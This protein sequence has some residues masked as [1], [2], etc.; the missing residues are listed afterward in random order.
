MSA[1]PNADSKGRLSPVGAAVTLLEAAHMGGLF[2]LLPTL[3]FQNSFCGPECSSNL[4]IDYLCNATNLQAPRWLFLWLLAEAVFYVAMKAKLAYLQSIDPQEA[5]FKATN[6]MTIQERQVL[7]D[8]VMKADSHDMLGYL[9][10]WFFD[11]PMEEISTEELRDFV[12][13]GYFDNRNQEHLSKEETQQ[14]SRFV[15]QAMEQ[16]RIQKEREQRDEGNTTA[17]AAK[18]PA[19]AKITSLCSSATFATDDS[20]HSSSSFSMDDDESMEESCQWAPIPETENAS[21]QLERH[22]SMFQNALVQSKNTPERELAQMM[23]KITELHKESQNSKLGAV[24]KDRP[25]RFGRPTADPLLGVR[26]FPLVVYLLVFLTTEIPGRFLLGLLGFQRCQVGS[27]TYHYRPAR[28]NNEEVNKKKIPLVF[29]H[30]IGVGPIVYLPFVAQMMLASDRA[31]FL[32]EVQSVSAFRPWIM[33]KDALTPDQVAVSLSL[34]LA[35]QGFGQATFAAHSFGTFWMTYMIKY[36][37]DYVAGVVF[38]DPVN[39]CL[40]NSTLTRRVVYNTPDAGDVGYMI[41]TDMMV[42]W[43]VQRNFSWTRGNMF[44]EDLGDK[45]CAVFL[46]GEDRVAPSALQQAYLESHKSF[47]TKEADDVSKEDFEVGNSLVVFAGCDHG[48]W[49]LNPVENFPKIV[50]SMEVLT[51]RKSVV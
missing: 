49:M 18:P 5:H 46:S 11:T 6:I 14:L 12:A 32:P 2:L 47:S 3:A 31:I 22:Q 8:R 28:S 30:G 25:Y 10:S 4:E 1:K 39:F 20:T 40:K 15:L 16:V 7:W 45:P 43:S 9:E 29:I 24:N 19:T 34:M 42:N 13:W 27:V 33:P 51:D 23:K 48:L 44:V 26:I 35:T 17:A 50:T 36:A 38:L 21:D 41:K 37:P